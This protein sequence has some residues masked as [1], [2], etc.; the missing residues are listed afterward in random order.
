MEKL[1]F[2]TLVFNPLYFCI[3]C[4]EIFWFCIILHVAVQQPLTEETIFSPLYIPAS[5][6]ID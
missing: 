4:E 1:K 6:T 2:Y 5:F 3:S